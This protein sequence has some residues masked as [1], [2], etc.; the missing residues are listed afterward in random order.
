MPKEITTS[1]LLRYPGGKYRARKLLDS[2][3]PPNIVSV[4][5][6]FAGGSSFELFLTRKGINVECADSYYLL[7]NF[8]R[9]VS[10]HPAKVAEQLKH[11]LDIDKYRFLNMQE[12]LNRYHRKEPGYH[13][14][15]QQEAI[16][17]ATMFY[18]VNRCSYSGATLSGGFSKDA[19]NTRFT[20]SSIDRVRNFYNPYMSVYCKTFYESLSD[21]QSVE[22]RH[23]LLFLDPPYMLKNSSLYGRKGDLHRGFNHDDLYEFVKM[24]T[25]PF[26]LTYNDCPEI[27]SMYSDYVITESK[28]SYGMN[29]SKKSSEMIITNYDIEL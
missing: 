22:S 20:E 15:T 13:V 16:D 2:I 4:L 24:Y 29:A 14:E 18:I 28:W 23:D 25:I 8:W 27:R 11:N 1:P 9:Q 17:I 7:I 19:A 10:T 5:S 12:Q 3:L 26:I 6:P 21:V